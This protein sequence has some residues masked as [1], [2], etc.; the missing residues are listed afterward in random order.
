MSKKNSKARKALKRIY[1]DGC[2]IERMGIRTITGYRKID[3]M[4]TFHHLKK[5]SKGGKA[6]VDNGANLSW[7][8]HEWLHSLPEEQQEEINNEIRRWK[9][10]YLV[11]KENQVQTYGEIEIPNLTKDE[12]CIIIETKETTQEEFIELQ[13]KNEIKEQKFNRSKE[14]QQ[15]RQLINE[16]VDTGEIEL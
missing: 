14:K 6:T 12:D 3:R 2:F 13:Q 5:K 9:M 8:N 15:L 1:G 10:N 7:E 11:M 4:I 16:L